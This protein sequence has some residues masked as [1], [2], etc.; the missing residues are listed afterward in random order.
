[1]EYF[2]LFEAVFDHVCKGRLEVRN[3]YIAC[4]KSSGLGITFDDAQMEKYRVL[5]CSHTTRNQ[6][7]TADTLYRKFGATKLKPI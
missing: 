6:S 3:G 2:P 1:M 4:P 5:L 7:F